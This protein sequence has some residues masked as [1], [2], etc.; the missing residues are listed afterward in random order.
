MPLTSDLTIDTTKFDHSKTDPQ[1]E[2]FNKKL[3]QIWKD[4]PRWYEVKPLC[5]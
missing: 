3:I 4:G 1:I 5:S 2:E